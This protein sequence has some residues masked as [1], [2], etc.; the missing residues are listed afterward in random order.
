MVVWLQ[1][2]P[3][4]A[5]R[6]RQPSGGRAA[7]FRV[8]QRS[9]LAMQFGEDLERPLALLVVEDVGGHHQLIGPGAAD[10]VVEAA[11]HGVAA[12]NDGGAQRVGENGAG[13]RIETG[14]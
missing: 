6:P 5:G 12:A 9:Q 7:V 4:T 13:I 3:A 1:T 2:G 14:L 8:T 11:A 10:K